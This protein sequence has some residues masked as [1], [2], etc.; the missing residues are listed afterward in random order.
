[1]HY[2]PTVFDNYSTHLKVVNEPFKLQIW[3]TA[4][5]EEYGLFRPLSYA[6]GESYNSSFSCPVVVPGLVDDICSGSRRGSLKGCCIHLDDARPHNSRQSNDC[7]PDTKAQWMRQPADSPDV[8][9]RDFFF[10]DFLKRR[11]RGVQL[12][13]REALKS[14]VRQIS[15]EIDREVLISVSMEWLERLQWVIKNGGEYCDH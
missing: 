11:L 4:G 9:P 3:D 7:L 12:A 8:A 1:M 6:Q 10:F 13:D 2:I 14:T 5:Q 15:D